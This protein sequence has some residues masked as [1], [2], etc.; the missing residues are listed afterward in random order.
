M[1]TRW[2]ELSSA[3][4]EVLEERFYVAVEVDS[5]LAEFDAVQARNTEDRSVSLSLL[6]RYATRGDIDLSRE[7]WQ[8]VSQNERLGEALGRFL[9]NASVAYFPRLAA[10]SSGE[11]A[12]RRGDGFALRLVPT[13]AREDQLYLIVTID[14]T[15]D[16]PFDTLTL[17]PAQGPVV[18]HPLPQPRD[19]RIQILLPQDSDV[20]Q[21]LRNDA[22]IFLQ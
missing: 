20:V 19:G 16:K 13:R 2:S 8:Q 4:R 22:E 9:R 21:A 15:F 10:A 6:Q 12:P 3:E 5:V 17:R 14:E 1:S 11:D 7:Q 18:R